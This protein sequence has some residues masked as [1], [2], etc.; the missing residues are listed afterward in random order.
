MKKGH[1]S[2]SPLLHNRTNPRK[3]RYSTFDPGA[4]IDSTDSGR[5][6]P[7]TTSI[8]DVGERVSIS[9]E[10]INVF[11]ENP[12]PSLFKRLCGG[13]QEIEK[14]TKKQVLFGGKWFSLPSRQALLPQSL[15]L[16]SVDYIV[17]YYDYVTAR[18][19]SVLLFLCILN[20]SLWKSNQIFFC[21]GS[22]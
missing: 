13:I 19:F 20:L 8:E 7:K 6:I 2:K 17:S 12:R 3:L 18:Y 16:E 4:S 11:V 10:N 14:P 21:C 9:W 1:D 5:L 22:S 15:S